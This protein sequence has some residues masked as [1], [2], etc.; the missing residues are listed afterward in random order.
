MKWHAPITLSLLWLL[1]APALA[2]QDLP[3]GTVLPVMM[4][5]TLDSSRTKAGDVL[6][7]RLMQDVSIGGGQWIRSGARVEGKVLQVVPRSGSA[8]ARVAVRVERLVAGGTVYQL[9]VRLRALASMDEVFA[10]QLPVGTF[11]DYGTSSSD[12]TTVQVGGAAVYRGDGTVRQAMEVVGRATDSGDVTARLLANPQR[13][14]P[15]QSGGDAPDV[16]LWVFSPWA[17]GSY[18]FEPLSIVAPPIDGERGVIL[19][20]SPERVLIRGGSGW[21]LQV[22]PSPNPAGPAQP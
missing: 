17:C 3:S 11:D 18:G 10:A 15:K 14:C 8:P 13:G 9:H 7:A 4:R 16:S 1:V 21:L 22:L 19:L 6:T 12:W 20:Q 2:A 5:T